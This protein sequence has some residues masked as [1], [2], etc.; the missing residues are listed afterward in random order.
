MKRVEVEVAD[1]DAARAEAIND[2]DDADAFAEASSELL[3]APRCRDAERSARARARRMARRD[4]GT[5][6]EEGSE[7]PR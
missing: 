6:R 2:A 3:P 7:A 1:D 5:A 4:E